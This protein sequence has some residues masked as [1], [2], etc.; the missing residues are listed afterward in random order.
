MTTPNITGLSAR[1]KHVLQE[2]LNVCLGGKALAEVSKSELAYLILT[3]R[4]RP[5]EIKGCG[6]KTLNEILDL[7]GARWKVVYAQCIGARFC[8]IRVSPMIWGF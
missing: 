2:G 8:T 5:I 6:R 4:L 3:E 7:L 1:A